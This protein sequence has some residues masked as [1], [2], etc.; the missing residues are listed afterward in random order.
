MKKVFALK[1]ETVSL[2][3]LSKTAKQDAAR[4]CR[5]RSDADLSKVDADNGQ[6]LTCPRL[7]EADRGTPVQ[8]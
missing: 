5:Q 3:V 2:S 8:A 6:T 1:G 4:L 7:Q